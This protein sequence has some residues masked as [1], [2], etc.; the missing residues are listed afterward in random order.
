[1]I[2]YKAMEDAGRFY[3]EIGRND[4]CPCGSGKKYKRCC[5]PLL[6]D[7]L[8]IDS[9]KF[10]AYYKI[11][12]HSFTN[13]KEFFR[14]TVGKFDR[15]DL[16]SVESFDDLIRNRKGW[17]EPL[18]WFIFN[19]YIL[20]GK[21]PL[22]LFLEEGSATEKEKEVLRR[23]DG[24]Y[25][26]IYEVKDLVKE[27]GRAKFIDLFSKKEYLVFDENLVSVEDGMIVFCRLIPHDRFYFVGYVFVP[28]LSRKP[29]RFSEMLNDFIEPFRRDNLPL[30]EILKIYG[31][32]LYLFVKDLSAP[33]DEEDSELAT[34]VYRIK[35]YGKVMSLL[36][37]S[38]YF[39]R[40][41]NFSDPGTFVCLRNPRSEL[42]INTTGIVT[43]EEDNT[44]ESDLGLVKV[45]KDYLEVLAPTKKRLEAVRNLLE[46]LVGDYITLESVG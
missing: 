38:P 9:L 34:S 43:P 44:D 14:D 32:R 35:D 26:S 39:Y 21:T 24:T 1:M 11:A 23:F 31:Y 15:K 28:W 10:S 3:I 18:D 36:Q 33:E 19:E 42:L 13:Y 40:G 16:A 17:E 30:E 45:E 7:S 5:L 6:E 20:R 46:E 8:A 12:Y 29:E 2:D 27:L 41:Q 25:W 22:Q 37:L 4:P